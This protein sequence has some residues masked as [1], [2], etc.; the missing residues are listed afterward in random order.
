MVVPEASPDAVPE[1]LRDL[2]VV[3]FAGHGEYRGLLVE[4]VKGLCGCARLVIVD[5]RGL[6]PPGDRN[7]HALR[8]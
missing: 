1:L 2:A 8:E 4:R 7:R 3:I 5:R 6:C